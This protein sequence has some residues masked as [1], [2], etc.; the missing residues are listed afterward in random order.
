MPLRSLGVILLRF[1][2]RN[3]GAIAWVGIGILQLDTEFATVEFDVAGV[4]S[5]GD[6][7]L[8][9]VGCPLKLQWRSLVQEF[10][11]AILLKRPNVPCLLTL[12]PNLH[13]MH[14]VFDA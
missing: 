2:T 8:V 7:A 11:A 9:Q 6:T 3:K 14:A 10:P 12:V 13:A 4:K 1:R 5:I